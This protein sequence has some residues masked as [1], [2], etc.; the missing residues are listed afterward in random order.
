VSDRDR[1]VR[2]AAARAI[3]RL[4]ARLDEFVGRAWSDATRVELQRAVADEVQ[5][6]RFLGYSDGA[7]VLQFMLER[8]LTANGDRVF[9]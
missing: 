7:T 1:D 5:V 3:A 9:E 6:L 8:F 4:Q 2:D